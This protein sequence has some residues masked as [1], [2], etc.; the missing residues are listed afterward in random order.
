[1][2]ICFSQVTT[3]HKRNFTVENSKKIP[4]FF[5]FKKI[6]SQVEGR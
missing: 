5:P 1:M 2:E 6:P 3:V 4:I